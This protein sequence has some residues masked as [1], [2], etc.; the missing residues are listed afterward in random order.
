[1][2]CVSWQVWWL[3]ILGWLNRS[4]ACERWAS[5]RLTE[6]EH[7]L[8]CL[9][10][11]A[12]QGRRKDDVQAPVWKGLPEGVRSG[13]PGRTGH[14]QSGFALSVADFIRRL[15]IA[16]DPRNP[17]QT[18]CLDRQDQRIDPD[19]TTDHPADIPSLQATPT[20]AGLAVSP[21]H[22]LLARAHA[23]ADAIADPDPLIAG[24]ARRLAARGLG[25]VRII[26]RP[27]GLAMLRAMG[28]CGHGLPDQPS[29]PAP[30]ICDSS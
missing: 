6:I 3:S 7:G 25:I 4:G 21:A 24:L 10:I 9:F 11:L 2:Q 12:L 19:N 28:L 13:R 26:L 16:P 8:R 27:G 23:L 29:A 15:G 22:R 17:C 20:E 30:A 1:M 14:V 18:A 5:R